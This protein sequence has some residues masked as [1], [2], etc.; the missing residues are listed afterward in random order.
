MKISAALLLLVGATSA[1]QP[2]A[3]ITGTQNK[4]KLSVPGASLT[5]ETT[6]GSAPPG[7]WKTSWVASSFVDEATKTAV[8]GKLNMF[9]TIDDADAVAQNCASSAEIS[10]NL[11]AQDTYIASVQLLGCNATKKQKQCVSGARNITAQFYGF[12]LVTGHPEMYQCKLTANGVT[13][14]TPATVYYNTGNGY[15]RAYARCVL[16]AAYHDDENFDADI[17]L[18]ENGMDLPHANW[19]PLIKF[20]NVGPTIMDLEST[21]VVVT[22]EDSDLFGK[23]RVKIKANYMDFYDKTEDLD[24]AFKSKSPNEVADEKGKLTIDKNTQEITVRF[25][26]DFIEGFVTDT[27]FTIYKTVTFAMTVTDSHGASTTKEL[28]FNVTQEQPSWNT[29]G[30]S[31]LLS[32]EARATILAR[33][34]RKQGEKMNLCYDVKRDKFTQTD[35]HTNCDKK[36]PLLMMMRR[37]GSDRVFGGF[38]HLGSAGDRCSYMRSGVSG[39][40][41]QG[42]T[43]TDRGWMFIVKD[44]SP[45][46]VEIASQKNNYYTYYNCYRYFLTWGGGHDST[47]NTYQCYCN[48]G[49]SYKIPGTYGY[50][51]NWCWGTYSFRTNDPQTA[52]DYYE[53]YAINQ[54]D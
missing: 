50:D 54:L 39:D 17:D 41:G 44:E 12:N 19:N 7:D 29:D 10:Q 38:N 30:S 52:F 51:R 43:R 35:F 28:S 2:K 49:Y 48:A 34:G 13:S 33:L 8:D 6:D 26:D 42:S 32:P 25:Q 23:N 24:V 40:D 22:G 27:D 37:A 47:C 18:L 21:T 15:Q 53:V 1:Q 5:F 4:V 20:V 45:E 46:T 14:Y 36:G 31:G 16:P 11:A 9:S 3:S